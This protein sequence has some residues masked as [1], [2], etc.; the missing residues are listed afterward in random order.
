[1]V[2]F[3]HGVS[4]LVVLVFVLAAC[5]GGDDASDRS[6]GGSGAST[7]PASVTGTIRL[8]S[9]TDGFDPGYLEAFEKAYPNITLETSAMGSNEEAIAKLQAGFEAD[10][11]NSC[12]DEAT[13]EMVQKGIY[14]PLDVSRLEH[15]DD[16][17]PSMTSLPGVQVDGQVYMLPID[18]GTSGIVYDADVVTTPPDSWSDLFDPQWA[19]RAAIEDIAVTGM[20]I[21]ALV[22][23]IED[24]INMDEAEIDQV[25]QYLIDHKSQFRTFWKGDAAVKSLFK[26]GE[27]VISSGYPDNAKAL[28]KEGVNAQ[29]AVANEGQFLWACGYGI[30]PDVGPENLD[31]AYALL[32]YYSSPEASLY[33][34]QHWNYQVANSATLDIAS[35][36]VIEEA[37]LEAPFDLENAIPASP[38]ANREAWVAAWTEV[39]AS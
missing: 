16:L 27:I 24:P 3:R 2:R 18:A 23:G 22:N 17:F 32:N 30:T 31:A 11:V 36:K 21:G 12:V 38:P 6:T 20:M 9:Y 14:A 5:G 28:Q 39:K 1:M 19:G 29:F 34:A 33:E 8:L 25:K 10:V 7:D 35:D 4:I 13:L 15:W 37:S 26:S